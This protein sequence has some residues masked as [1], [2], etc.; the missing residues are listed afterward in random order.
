ML[1]AAALCPHPP[2]LDPAVA[3]R[4]APELNDC[5]AACTAALDDLDA[6]GA[7]LLVV[8]GA[9]ATT[10]PHDAGDVGSLAP[11]GVDVRRTLAGARAPAT[12][13]AV[14]PLSLSIA[15][16]LLGGA[17]RPGPL[18]G[19]QVAVD[20]APG[21]CLGLGA[22][23][24]ASAPRVALLV[25]ADLSGRR[26]PTAPGYLDPRSV[27]FDDSV[28]RALADGDTAALAA[29]DPALAHDLLVGGRAALQVLAGAGP[30]GPGTVRAALD[31][32]GVRYVVASWSPGR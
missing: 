15:G 32:Y 14:L 29:I 24:A 25:M 28:E 19:R 18:I 27:P 8:V 22:G 21:E 2:L 4:A 3:G 12:A 16:W 11:F 30:L 23:L 31:P 26:S 9:G 1:V 5:R 20:A 7:D 17:R 13:P 10:R 6:A